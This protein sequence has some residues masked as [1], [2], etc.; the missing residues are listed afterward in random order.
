MRALCMHCSGFGQ[1][2]AE[3]WMPA[4]PWPCMRRMER[5]VPRCWTHTLYGLDG[6]I[7]RRY[8]FVLGVGCEAFWST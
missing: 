2:R 4:P 1:L 6:L 7:Q 8:D 3:S 5:C